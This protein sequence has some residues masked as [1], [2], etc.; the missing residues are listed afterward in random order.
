MSVISQGFENTLTINNVSTINDHVNKDKRIFNATFVTRAMEIDNDPV[1]GLKE[2]ELSL[3]V[4]IPCSSESE[5]I[6]V[7]EILFRYRSSLTRFYIKTLLVEREAEIRNFNDKNTGASRNFVARSD[8][9]TTTSLYRGIEFIQNDLKLT[10]EQN[11]SV[12]A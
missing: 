10:Q 11:K 7:K 3:T 5:V 12:K 2:S 6:Q 4:T 8:K 9:A 1:T